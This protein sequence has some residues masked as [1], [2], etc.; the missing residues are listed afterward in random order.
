MGRR[1]ISAVVVA[2]LLSMLFAASAQATNG[3]LFFHTAD[4]NI[5]CAI[6]K[7]FKKKRRHGRFI[8]GI[9][10]GARCDISQHTFVAPPS[11]CELDYGDSVEV[12]DHGPGGY[13]CHGDTVMDPHATVAQAG[14]VFNLGRYSCTVSATSPASIRCVNFR[15]G[16]GFEIAAAA[17]TVF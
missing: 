16:H 14:Q 15:D 8:P 3:E 2:G 12:G 13:T 11:P 7:G 9:P 4:N 5:S 6:F 10:G 17:A 1:V